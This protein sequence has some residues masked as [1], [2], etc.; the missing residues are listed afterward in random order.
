MPAKHGE[1]NVISQKTMAAAAAGSF[2]I[3]KMRVK[4]AN[5]AIWAPPPIPGSCSVEPI[6]VSAS[7]NIAAARLKEAKDPPKLRITSKKTN[8]SKDQCAA[9]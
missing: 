6:M 8:A 7:A 1:A 5:V 4:T 3:L 2:S 9:E